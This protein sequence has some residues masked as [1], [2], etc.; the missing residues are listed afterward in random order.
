MSQYELY[1]VLTVVLLPFVGALVYPYIHRAVGERA[2][3]F[4]TLV[5]SVSFGL[6]VWLY[7]AQRGVVGVDW[8]PTYSIRLSFLLDGLSLMMGGIVSGVGVLIT[9]YARGYMHGED[10]QGRFFAYLLGFMGSML[11]VVFSNSLVLL[12]VFWELTSFTSFMLIGFY[13]HDSDSVYGARKSMVITVSGGLFMLVG[14]LLIHLVTGSFSL[15][16][17]TSSSLSP[18]LAE[19]PLYL[20]ILV[21]VLLGAATK[22]AQVPFHI[23]LPNA[24]EAPTPVSAFLHSATMVKAGVYLLGR[25]SPALSGSSFEWTL[26]VSLLG[27]VTMTAAA[28]LAVGATDIKELLAYSTVSHLGLITATFGFANKIG[29]EAGVFHILNHATFKATLFMVAG[30]VAHS[31]GTRSI[32]D[33]GGL[34]HR[35]PFVAAFAGI[36]SLSMAGVP[37]FNGF[38]SKEFLYEASLEMS[39]TVSWGWIFPVVAVA[40]SVFTFVYSMGF[41]FRVFWGEETEYIRNHGFHSPSVPSLVPP[42]ILVVVIGVISVDPTVAADLV[43]TEAIGSVYGHSVEFHPHLPTSLTTAFG[44]SI[45]TVLI[46]VALYTRYDLIHR[47]VRCLLDSEPRLTV[48]YYYDGFMSTAPRLSKATVDRIDKGYLRTYVTLM[49]LSTV[50]VAVAGYV[51]G[52]VFPVSSSFSLAFSP[53]TASLVGVLLLTVIASIAV[54]FAPSHIAG[55]LML[56]IIG[57]MVGIFYVIASAPDL[58]ITQIVVETVTLV[59]FLVVLQRLPAFYQER[60]PGIDRERDL[61]ISLLVG[62]TVFVTVIGARSGTSSVPKIS[63]YFIENSVEL[64][65]GHNVVN[66]ILVDFRGF[67]TL[68]ESAVVM[69]AALGVITLIASRTKSGGGSE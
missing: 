27:M 61:L 20:P 58:A 42:G 31:V 16:E 33:L 52:D 8:I 15:A 67:D 55:V 14:F 60:K 32:D 24:M 3:Y 59:F 29:A 4:A 47:S 68:G 13:T 57:F 38:Y 34:R 49:L 1:A 21:L 62:A 2:A 7:T 65:G 28:V 35:M 40:G 43:V 64:G 11:G 36:A 19:S 22:S 9:V 26:V 23:W 48:N 12:F 17:I 18:S 6:V 45:L 54:L 46:G 69:M 53:D 41:F 66:V 63:D 37:P 44:M 56:S 25:L 5:A 30:I 51:V 50:V 39:H 10:R